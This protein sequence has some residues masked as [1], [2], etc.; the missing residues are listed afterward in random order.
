MIL[1]YAFAVFIWVTI[2][3]IAITLALPFILLAEL[4]RKRVD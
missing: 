4:T 1:L 3:A 2:K